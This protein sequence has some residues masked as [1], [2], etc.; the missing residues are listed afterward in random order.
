MVLT[1]IGEQRGV[2]LE[3]LRWLLGRWSPVAGVAVVDER[4]ARDWLTR[5]ARLG[6]VERRSLL[7]EP[8]AELTRHGARSV[9]VRWGMY[10]MKIGAVR[11]AR[12][13]AVVRWFLEETAAAGSWMP[14]EAFRTQRVGELAQSRRPDGAW[15]VD[16]ALTAVEVELNRK[17]GRWA[18]HS[19]MEQMPP[20]V[21]AVLW[22]TPPELAAWLERRLAGAKL[23]YQ[24]RRLPTLDPATH[25]AGCR[26]GACRLAGVVS[27]EEMRQVWE[28]LAASVPEALGGLAAPGHRSEWQAQSAGTFTAGGAG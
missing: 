26:C 19:I 2:P 15:L 20:E 16:D 11:H 14:E 22:F 13:V 9:G 6:V 5:M 23:P 4:T 21:D 25:A 28:P 1:W 3:L 8:W 17:S 24:V 27:T 10:Q 12:A 18:Y 7:G